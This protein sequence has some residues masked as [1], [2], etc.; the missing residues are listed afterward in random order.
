[1]FDGAGGPSPQLVSPRIDPLN[2][3]A[4]PFVRT[5]VLWGIGLPNLLPAEAVD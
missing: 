3:S 1:M 2:V 5:Y 4:R